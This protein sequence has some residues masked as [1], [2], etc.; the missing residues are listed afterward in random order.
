MTEGERVAGC[1]SWRGASE[2]GGSQGG[3]VKK[4][5]FARA[6]PGEGE[7]QVRWEEGN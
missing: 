3:F 6:Y 2:R 4:E 7:K 5:G 1:K